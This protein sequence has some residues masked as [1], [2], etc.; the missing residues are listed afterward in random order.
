MI[1]AEAIQELWLVECRYICDLQYIPFLSD[2]K[3]KLN[4]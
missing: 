1:R 4:I 2:V 3:L